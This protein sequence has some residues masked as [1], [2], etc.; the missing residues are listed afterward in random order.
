MSCPSP[1]MRGT[2]EENNMLSFKEFVERLILLKDKKLSN[3][4]IDDEGWI[5]IE[6]VDR[7][8]YM[9]MDHHLI[10]YTERG[11]SPHYEVYNVLEKFGIRVGPG[12]T[13]SVGWLTGII[14]L[15]NGRK[16]LFG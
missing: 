14:Y 1:N 9:S 8:V 3:E 15:G 16:I 13:D 4:E 2:M 12:E 11:A 10:K 6:I 7:D 5:E